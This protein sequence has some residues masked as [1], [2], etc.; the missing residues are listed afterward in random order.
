MRESIGQLQPDG[1]AREQLREAATQI[2]KE[3]NTALAGILLP[4]QLERL[5]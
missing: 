2:N 5:S 3:M 4:H 1:N